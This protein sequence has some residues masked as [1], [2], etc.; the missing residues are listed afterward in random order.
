MLL[1]ADLAKV[2]VLVGG[3]VLRRHS[4]TGLRRSPPSVGAGRSPADVIISTGQSS[5]A[6]RLLGLTR[7][8]TS[9]RAATT[10]S[11]TLGMC[12]ACA[13]P[14]AR[15]LS[16]AGLLCRSIELIGSS[17]F[18]RERPRRGHLHC[19]DLPLSVRHR[20]RLH[21]G[22]RHSGHGPGRADLVI[23]QI[24]VRLGAYDGA[25][26]SDDPFV[27]QRLAQADAKPTAPYGSRTE[28]LGMPCPQRER[29]A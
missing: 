5:A 23:E 1:D 8:R 11:T 12:S 4:E 10:S 17:T 7:R 6:G 29:P 19:A 22:S 24:Q 9:A 14:A 26:A 27:R 16:W 25:K 20:L 3:G 18:S 28:R 15:T 13:A 2:P 21:P